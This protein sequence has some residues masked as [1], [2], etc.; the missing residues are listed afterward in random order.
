MRFPIRETNVQ[1]LGRILHPFGDTVAY[2]SKNRK[3]RPFVPT[4]VSEIT[5]AH[6][7]PLRIFQRVIPC[8]KVKSWGYQMVKKS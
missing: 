7:E 6:G 5:H 2:R 4:P 3:N 1:Y 8:Q